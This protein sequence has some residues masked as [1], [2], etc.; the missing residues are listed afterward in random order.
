MR[1][2]CPFSV[3]GQ[4]WADLTHS[5]GGVDFQGSL[6]QMEAASLSC[7]FAISSEL[8]QQFFP[9]VSGFPFL[10][11]TPQGFWDWDVYSPSAACGQERAVPHKGGWGWGGHGGWGEEWE[12][13]V[14]LPSWIPALAQTSHPPWPLSELTLEALYL[15]YAE[16]SS[17]A[18]INLSGLEAEAK[19]FCVG[20][21]TF[22]FEEINS[23]CHTK[24]RE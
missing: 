19:C 11:L 21:M 1:I 7:R 16:G 17:L 22:T 6:W 12:G 4:T 10:S 20:M 14:Q 24:E 18:P 9:K 15:F 5:I 23:N 8:V 13:G 2:P 3:T